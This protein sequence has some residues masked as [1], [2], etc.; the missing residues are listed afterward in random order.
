MKKAPTR[1]AFLHAPEKT[2]TST[3]HTVHKALNQ[4]LRQQ[5]GVFA[6]AAAGR[7]WTLPRP[8]RWAEDAGGKPPLSDA[9]VVDKVL[10][11][12]VV[13]CPWQLMLT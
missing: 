4:Q 9:E 12:A 5:N 6:Q 2:R 8:N 13:F 11:L 10:L 1:G 7:A 3:D